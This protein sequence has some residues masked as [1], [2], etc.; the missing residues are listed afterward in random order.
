MVDSMESAVFPRIWI[1]IHGFGHLMDSRSQ[2]L[3]QV[4][5]PS[6]TPI[7]KYVWV[8][9]RA[10][11]RGMGILPEVEVPGPLE[12]RDEQM[13]L[14]LEQLLHRLEDEKNER[15]GRAS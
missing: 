11:M 14:S 4:A 1:K 12:P 5:Q 3:Y 2:F 7:S 10:I 15:R 8:N 6:L 13:K 9:F